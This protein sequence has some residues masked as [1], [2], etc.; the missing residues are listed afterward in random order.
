MSL[1]DDLVK[2]AIGSFTRLQWLLAGTILG[3]FFG[4]VDT[5]LIA[6][7]LG[8]LGL[9]VPA[10]VGLPTTFTGYFFAG[11]VLGGFAPR[12]IEWEPPLGVLI[13][14]EL[15]MAGYWG[16]SGHGGWFIVYFI[17]MPAIAVGVS[18]LGLTLARKRLDKK[19]KPQE[20]R[21]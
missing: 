19:T 16:L 9:Q 11:M 21:P 3:F 20:V 1:V 15:M 5:L 12:S 18:Y 4:F 14:V 10:V 6:A 7:L 8:G 2:P 13:C 17:L